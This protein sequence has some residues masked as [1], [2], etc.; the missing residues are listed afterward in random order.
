MRDVIER[1]AGYAETDSTGTAV[2]FRADYENVLASANPSGERGKPAEE[3]GEEAVR[4]LVA[5]DAED[6]AAD[7][8]LAD[9]LLVWLTIAGA[10]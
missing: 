1:T 4:E 3:V 2:T 6:A 7:R 8:Y 10:N 9:Q 5:F